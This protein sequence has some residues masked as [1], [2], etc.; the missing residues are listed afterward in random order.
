MLKR[1]QRQVHRWDY[2]LQRSALAIACQGYTSTSSV[3]LQNS[4]EGL[5]R[6]CLLCYGRY[7]RLRPRHAWWPS[8][9]DGSV[10][11]PGS[12]LISTSSIAVG[13]L[14]VELAMFSCST[15]TP[16]QDN[17]P[18]PKPTTTS[19]ATPTPSPT[20][21]DVCNEIC[22]DVCSDVGQ[23]PPVSEDCATI[24]DAITIMNGS[25]A[26]EFE[27]DPNH[28]QQLTFGTCR[29]FFENVGPS[30]L[31]YCWTSLAQ[32]A[33]AAASA[34]LPPVQPVNSEGL[35]IPSDGLWQVGVAHS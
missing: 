27:V 2:R 23:L 26:P 7:N 6:S 25:V 3:N 5:H 35:C 19:S 24:V 20:P 30:P 10:A 8:A 4:Y 18:K 12:S 16:E 9:R 14:S 15:V 11:C 1:G 34:C 17:L 13:N 21:T 29:F 28:M 32:V 31:S 33:S 22:T